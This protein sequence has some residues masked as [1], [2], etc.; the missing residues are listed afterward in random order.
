MFRKLK[1]WLRKLNGA[2]RDAE[3]VAWI[4]YEHRYFQFLK[5]QERKKHWES[6]GILF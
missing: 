6:R 5:Q 4:G 3:L 2:S 1:I